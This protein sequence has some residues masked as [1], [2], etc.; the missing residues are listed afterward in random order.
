[1]SAPS[2]SPRALDGLRVLDASNLIAGPLTTM[3]LA[4]LGA[5]VIKLEHPR[6]GDSLRTHGAQKDGHGLWWKVLGRG[7]RSVTLNLSHPKG[8]AVFRRLAAGVDLVVENYRP[9]TMQRWGLGY[10]VL[11]R[12]N[13]GL[14][15]AHVTGFGQTG[16]LSGNPGFGTLAESMSGFAH[17]NGAPDGPPTLPPFG[18]ADTVTG[19]TTAFAVMTALWARRATGLGQEVDVSII[20]PLLT[21]LEPQLIEYDQMNTVMGRMGNRS[22][23]NA[24][25]NMYLARDNRWV[26]IS[27]ST[28]STA[29]RLV[30]LVGRPDFLEH[31]WFQNSHERAAHTDE[32]DE[33]VGS[34]V[35]AR[36][37]D[38][39][40]A[41]CREVG[42][43]ASVIFTVPDIMRDPQYAAVGA[44][45]TVDDPDLGPLRMANTPFRLSATPPRISWSGPQLGEHTD[46]VL[47]A[48]GLSADELA[49]LRELGV[50]L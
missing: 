5:D 14:V 35:L 6:G 39:V 20:E 37:A 12:D 49:E 50:V 47:G 33:A 32:L 25:R 7:K 41:A 28:Q 2:E 3:L 22:P 38:D 24:P 15:M 9:G 44:I 46:E 40:L 42:A 27:T 23:V 17:R 31:E 8:Q 26:A 13:P 45:A 1:M 18:L 21:V 34:W 43:P 29:D 10:D 19:I 16:P 4:D 48:L 36:D 11:K 30:T